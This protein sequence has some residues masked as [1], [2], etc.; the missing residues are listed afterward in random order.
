MTLRVFGYLILISR[1]FFTTFYFSIFSLVLVLI[2]KIHQTLKTVF[3]YISKHRRSP[4]YSATRRI[5]ISLFGV[6]K[7]DQ[8]WSFVFDILH[9]TFTGIS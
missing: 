1:G 9:K 5:F 2:E 4:E 7:Y 8:T 3:D 6:W